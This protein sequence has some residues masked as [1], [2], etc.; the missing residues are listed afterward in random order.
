MSRATL[1]CV[2]TAVNRDTELALVE[3]LRQ[4]DA[5]AFDEVYAAFN[6]RVLKA[7]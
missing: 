4:G 3:R 5:D 7:A 6:T 1:S 2:N